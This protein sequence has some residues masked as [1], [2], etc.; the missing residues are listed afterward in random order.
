MAGHPTGGADSVTALDQQ[1]GVPRQPFRTVQLMAQV[2]PELI[3]SV[4]ATAPAAS[5]EEAGVA[6]VLRTFQP[7]QAAS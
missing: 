7:R 1:E 6:T 3:L 5:F 2:N 4:V